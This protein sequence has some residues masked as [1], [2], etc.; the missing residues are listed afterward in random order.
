VLD[1]AVGSFAVGTVLN[2]AFINKQGTKELQELAHQQN[3]RTEFKVLR[4][5]FVPKGN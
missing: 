4:T 2:E 5:D 1:A 3:R